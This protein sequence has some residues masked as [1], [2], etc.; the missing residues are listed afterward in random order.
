MNNDE[1]KNLSH[2]KI[3]ELANIKLD[4]MTD[5]DWPRLTSVIRLMKLNPEKYGA[6]LQELENLVNKVILS[7]PELLSDAALEDAHFV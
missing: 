1:T 4:K 7:E 6:R 2:E 3:E 5:D